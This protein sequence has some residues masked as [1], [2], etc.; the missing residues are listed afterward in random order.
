VADNDRLDI[1][2]QQIWDFRD[3]MAV[4]GY[5]DHPLIVTEFGVLMPVEFGFDL[6]RVNA[7]MDGAFAFLRTATSTALGTQGDPTDG[8]RLVQRWAWF[9]LD[10]PPWN[11]VT[12]EGFNGNLFDPY[13]TGITGYGIHFATHTASLPPLGFWDLLPGGL[14]FE[15][16][17]PV[18]EGELVNRQVEVEIRNMGN[19]DAGPVVVRLAYDGPVS[20]QLQHSVTNLPAGSS[21]WVAFE[22]TQL[23]Q[24]AYTLTVSVDPD[25]LVSETTECDN[26]LTSMMM[27]PTDVTYLPLVARK[28]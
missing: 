26:V 12:N 6:A 15:P 7:F 25:D 13:S 14:R 8:N 27:V 10:V 17:G 22:L 21:T 23:S 18:G 20:G 5:E 28:R 24:G 19:L 3:W 2:I 11:P 4:V 9:S 1:F 16:L